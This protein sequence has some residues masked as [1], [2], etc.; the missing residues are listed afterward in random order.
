MNLSYNCIQNDELETYEAP[1]YLLRLRDLADRFHLENER[2]DRL[3]PKL[4]RTTSFAS[5]LAEARRIENL[6]T[7]LIRE[8]ENVGCTERDLDRAIRVFDPRNS[9]RA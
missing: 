9:E 1:I 8:A 2:W 7:E 3:N 4:R 6:K 5:L